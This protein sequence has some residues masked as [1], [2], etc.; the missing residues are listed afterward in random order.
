MNQTTTWRYAGTSGE[1]GRLRLG[2]TNVWACEWRRVGTTAEVRDPVYQQPFE[3]DVYE[4]ET[5]SGLTQFAAGEFS[6]GVWGFYVNQAPRWWERML[7]R[8][9]IVKA[10]QQHPVAARDQRELS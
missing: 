8:L 4:I 5:P 9:G 3:F 6:N 10:V 7:L 2:R 1:G